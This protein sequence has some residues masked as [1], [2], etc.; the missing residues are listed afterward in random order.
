MGRDICRS[1]RP[2]SLATPGEPRC[3]LPSSWQAGVRGCWK[4][5]PKTPSRYGL[6]S[7]FPLRWTPSQERSS[8]AQRRSRASWGNSSLESESF[9]CLRNTPRFP[10]LE[11]K[12]WY[13]LLPSGH[14]LRFAHGVCAQTWRPSS[15]PIHKVIFFLLAAVVLIDNNQFWRNFHLGV[16]SMLFLC[17]EN[18]CKIVLK[19]CL[20]CL[21]SVGTIHIC[22][23]V[24]PS[25]PRWKIT[26]PPLL[27]PPPTLN[28]SSGPVVCVLTMSLFL[29]VKADPD[30]FPVS[31]NCS[32]HRF[33]V[34]LSYSGHILCQCWSK[35]LK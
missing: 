17:A 12:V 29:L 27:P 14:P 30:I 1:V 31:L 4:R 34:N 32:V 22:V 10:F 9:C 13:W 26:P 2:C 24:H 21:G 18:A 6:V 20:T 3:A 15:S 25:L 19:R 7:V 16:F 8:S 35:N 23:C 33:L 11:I 28:Y 5:S